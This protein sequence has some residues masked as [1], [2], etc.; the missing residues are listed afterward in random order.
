MEA[1]MSRENSENKEENA[2]SKPAEELRIGTSGW[3]YKEWEGVFYPNSKTPKLTYYSQIFSTAEIDSTFYANPTRGLVLGWA[4]NTPEDFEFAAKIPK[5]VT[6]DRQLDLSR[7]AEVELRNFLD[8]LNPLY[9]A[10]KLGPLLIQL[11]PSF[12]IGSMKILRE[13]LEALPDRYRFAIEFRNKSWLSEKDEL[14]ELLGK[15]KVANTIV[16]EPLLPPD[17]TTTS[18]FAFFR[19][20]GRGRAPWY[21]YRYTEEELEPWIPRVHEVLPKVKR[22]YGYY[23]NHFHG[24]AIENGLEFLEMLGAATDAQRKVLSHV[25]G[26]IEGNRKPA[27]EEEEEGEQKKAASESPREAKRKPKRSPTTVERGQTSL[28]QYPE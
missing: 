15:Y 6:H 23:N 27:E 4:R 14:Y 3:S 18:D 25:R 22:S 10:G 9:D 7:G 24:Y 20:H 5:S 28:T 11:P 16:D 26:Y 13:F 12:A 21:N 17:T 2:E 8:L 1:E 19:W